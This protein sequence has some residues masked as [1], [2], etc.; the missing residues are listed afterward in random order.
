MARIAVRLLST[1][2]KREPMYASWLEHT[3]T[4]AR[5]EPGENIICASEKQSDNSIDTAADLCRRFISISGELRGRVSIPKP[6]PWLMT[7]IFIKAF[8]SLWLS[9]ESL[10][11]WASALWQQGLDLLCWLKKKK[12][13]LPSYR[14]QTH[15][16]LTIMIAGGPPLIT[17]DTVC[18]LRLVCQLKHKLALEKC[19]I[20]L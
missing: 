7:A 16:L 20:L 6:K 18:S 14:F 13:C 1:E 10:F 3:W 9:A 19:A 12:C 11:Y 17:E 5:R 8:I 4:T 15:F 2:V